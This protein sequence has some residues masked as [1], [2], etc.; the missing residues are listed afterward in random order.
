MLYPIKSLQIGLRNGRM[1]AGDWSKALCAREIAWCRLGDVMKIR[2][3]ELEDLEACL[4]LEHA[5][6]TDHVWQMEVQEDAA[7]VRVSFRTVR[8]P[9]PV[10]VPYPR[11]R[12]ALLAEWHRLDCFLVAMDEK[13]N[14]KDSNLATIVGY[15]TMAEHDWHQIGWISNLVVAPEYRRERIATR[16]LHAAKE[17]AREAGLRRLVV[18]TQTKNSPAIKFLEKMGFSFCGYNDRYYGNEDIALFF[19]VELR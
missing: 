12:E 18:E 17:W 13:I 15:V 9:R 11:D 2:P 6:L 4:N 1:V 7:R 14:T 5:Y 16:L 10:Y 8:L 19:S 3:A